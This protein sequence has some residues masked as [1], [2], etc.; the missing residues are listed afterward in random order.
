MLKNNIYNIDK[1]F[2]YNTIKAFMIKSLKMIKEEAL[3]NIYNDSKGN[4]DHPINV[5]RL[6]A[7][8]T[9]LLKLKIRN[10]T[11]YLNWRISILKRD[12]FTCKICHASLKENK[13]LRLDVHHPKTFDDICTENNVSTIEQALACKELWDTNNGVSICYTCHKDVEKLRT[14]LRNMFTLR[15]TG[16]LNNQI[17]EP[18]Y[19]RGQNPTE[20]EDFSIIFIAVRL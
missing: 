20:P 16:K 2:D 8:P 3:K 1:E 13:S 4:A 9:P 12:N 5:I 19:M 15:N 14:K 17:P 6:S 11:K 7:P 18:F 10:T